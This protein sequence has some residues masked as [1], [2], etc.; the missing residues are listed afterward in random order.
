MD[1]VTKKRSATIENLKDAGCNEDFIEQFMAAA[2]QGRTKALFT[3]LEGHR[4]SL[5]DAVHTN[6]KKI[7]LLDY[8]VFQMKKSDPIKE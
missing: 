5:L 2:E 6:Q 4:N 7:D 3:L 8:L 1:Y